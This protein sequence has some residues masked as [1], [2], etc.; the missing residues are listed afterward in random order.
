MRR[1]ILTPRQNYIFQEINLKLSILIKLLLTVCFT[2]NCDFNGTRYLQYSPVT[3]P[4]NIKC[5]PSIIKLA[6]KLSINYVYYLIT[7]IFIVIKTL[8]R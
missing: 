5:L 7:T 4:A 3:L 2:Q 6:I 8:N 1:N